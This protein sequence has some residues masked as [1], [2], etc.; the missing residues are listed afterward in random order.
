MKI[1]AKIRKKDSRFICQMQ[2]RSYK[3]L[4]SDAKQKSGS[5]QV[6]TFLSVKILLPLFLG[7]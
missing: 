1:H 6:M 4:F 7:T 5:F 3:R 2:G